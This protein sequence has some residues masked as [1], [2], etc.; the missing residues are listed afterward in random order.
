[1]YQLENRTGWAAGLYP[2]W[3]RNRKLQQTLVFKVGYEFDPSGE[4]SPL[5]Q[6]P[7]EEVDCYSGDPETSSLTAA[8]EIMPFKKGGEILLFG[9]A[10]S[11]HP[12]LT[13]FPV[14]VSLR[15]RNNQFWEKELRIFGPR[16]WQRKFLAAVPSLPQVIKAP[17]PLVYENAFGG[18]DPANPEKIFAANPSG[19]GFS[20]RGLRTKGLTLPQIEGASKVIEGPAS[21]VTPAGFGPLPPHWNPRSKET[22]EIDEEAIA[23]GCCPWAKEPPES[24]YNTAPSDQRFDQPFEGEMTLSLKS[25]VADAPRDV[26]INLPEIRPMVSFEGR[27]RKKVPLPRCDTLVID[28][29]N[30]HIHLIWR[31]AL[32][33]NPEAPSRGRIVLRDLAAEATDD[34]E[35]KPVAEKTEE[36]VLS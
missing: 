23:A 26:L 22:V 27:H 9:S 4:L 28:T 14:Q 19:V 21:R 25:L 2:G 1:M 30:R 29:D 6:P 15:Q 24:M 3:G 11:K 36:T 7:I 34:R 13:G 16:V 8:G 10:H 33:L 31:S 12:N 32:P 5:P 17:V 35:K 20:F 18:A